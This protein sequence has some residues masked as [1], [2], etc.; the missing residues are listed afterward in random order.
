MNTE[1]Y[2][3]KR[4]DTIFWALLLI[5]WGLRWSVLAF[6]PEGSGLIG[7]GLLLFGANAA[8]RSAGL[9]TNSNNTFFGV[10]SLL[11]G[12]VLVFISMLHLSAT[13]PVFETILVVVGL[14][15]L[16]YAL[17]AKPIVTPSKQ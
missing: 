8:L 2:F 13:L 7:T 6:L 14:V 17:I 16:I 3:R 4:L 5:W 1:R 10:I 11:T 9:P 12:G 15:L